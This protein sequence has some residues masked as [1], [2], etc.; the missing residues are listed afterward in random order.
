MNLVKE[1]YA[2]Y[3]HDSYNGTISTTSKCVKH[4]RK[5]Y[6]DASVEAWLATEEPWEVTEKWGACKYVEYPESTKV[7]FFGWAAE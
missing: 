1:A 6:S 4:H 5:F 7:A 3:G 2:E